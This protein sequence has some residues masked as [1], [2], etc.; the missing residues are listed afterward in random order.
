MLTQHQWGFMNSATIILTNLIL[1]LLISSAAFAQFEF[2]ERDTTAVSHPALS[3]PPPQ[4]PME[5]PNR[6]SRN[7]FGGRLAARFQFVLDSM[8]FI[9]NL[10]GVSAAVTLPENGTWLGAG[11]F[12]DPV[13]K[14]S[15]RTDMLFEIDSNTKSFVAAI[16]LQMIDEGVMTLEDEMYQWLPSF[17]NV[18]STMTIRQI[19]QHT[20][21]VSDF[22]NDNPAAIIAILNNPSYFWTPEY[23]LSWV[24]APNFLPGAGWSY[25]NTG[26]IL[27]GMIIRKVSGSDTFAVPLRQ[28]LLEPLGLQNTYMDIE[29]PL[30][31]ELAHGWADLNGDGILND[32]SL[33]PRTSWASAV[34]TAGGIVA[35]AEDLAKWVELL[36][37]GHVLSSAAMQQ[38][39]TMVPI[40][41]SNQTYGLGIYTWPLFGKTLRGHAGGGIGYNSLALYYRERGV[42]L[43]VIINQRGGTASSGDI[44]AVL[45]GEVLKYYEHPYDH[46]YALNADV[47]PRYLQP[48]IDSTVVTANI[49]NPDNHQVRVSATYAN[50]DSSTLDS[51]EMFDDGQHGDGQAGDS[52]YGAF[53]G[54]LSDESHYRIEVRTID[55]D[56]AFA[57]FR[58]AT[59][60]TIGP[61]VV[62][63]YEI[64][65]QTSVAFALK[66]HLRN[67][68][69]TETA[70]A[71]TAHI[72]TSDT[73]V[74][75]ILYNDQNLGNI[76]AGDTN[77][78]GYYGVYTQNNPNHIN[79]SIIISSEG[80]DF[81]SDSIIVSVTGL[82][83]KETN[84]PL[85]YALKQNYPNPFNPTTT[86]EFSIPK[87]EFVTLK[88][89]NILG[90]VVATLAFEKLTVGS[91]KYDWDASGLA[92]GV[93]LYRIQAGD[94]IGVKKMVILR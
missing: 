17:K 45:F 18:D 49:H 39:R 24:L 53:L 86:I 38:M 89:Y 52:I 46:P 21:G 2:Q 28:R 93:Y 25:S 63:H 79:F 72:S 29:E 35:T 26:Y 10:M 3:Y 42:S 56:T 27:A 74:T 32:L 47:S 55:L 11:G 61:V 20:S 92:S 12:S 23:S 87:A 77:T 13:A 1:S 60:T 85:E 40:S 50:A 51:L 64:P 6:S 65:Q 22:L 88:I 9:H 54:P 15:I 68:G 76:A 73:N 90:E 82:A 66:L 80:R 62:D 75:A 84:I 70:T 44:L 58:Y 43:A 14:D 91:Y 48:M 36:H 34:W 71:V 78:S 81:W 57:H 83:E 30:G 19:L 67:D 7:G 37:G 33:I 16:I 8:L 5:I 69:L 94:Y 41:N 4:M 59:C 31:G